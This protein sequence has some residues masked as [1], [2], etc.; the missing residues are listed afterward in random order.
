MSATTSLLSCLKSE[1][2]DLTYILGIGSLIAWRIE[3]M[4]SIPVAASVRLLDE[5]SDNVHPGVQ[6]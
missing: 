3:L 4:A 6:D 5:N 1:W 2:A